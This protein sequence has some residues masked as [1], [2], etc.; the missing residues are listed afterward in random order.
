[1]L[2][3][4][5]AMR[6]YAEQASA[7]ASA[8]SGLILHAVNEFFAVVVLRVGKYCCRWA[9]VETLATMQHHGLVGKMPHQPELIGDQQIGDAGVLL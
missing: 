6:L 2:A 8:A 5:F 3:F 9:V 7:V 4:L 1:M